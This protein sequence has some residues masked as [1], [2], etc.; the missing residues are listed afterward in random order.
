MSV[1]Q[2][3]IRNNIFYLLRSVSSTLRKIKVTRRIFGLH[4]FSSFVYDK[5]RNQFMFNSEIYHIDTRQHANF[6]QLSVNLTEYQTEVY[7]LGVKVLNILPSYIKIESDNPKK[8]K[9]ILQKFLYKSP[10]ILQMNI[11]NFKKIIFI[12][13]R[14]KL[15]FE[16]LAH[17]IDIHRCLFYSLTTYSVFVSVFQILFCI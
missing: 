13:I 17:K 16:S 10:F 14:L 15:V 3:S 8:F 5:N 12:Y 6:H 7:Y 2:V 1:H 9:F 4:S 11:Q